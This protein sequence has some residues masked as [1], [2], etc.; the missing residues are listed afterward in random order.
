[1]RYA[2]LYPPDTRTGLSTRITNSTRWIIDAYKYGCEAIHPHYKL[3]T[4]SVIEKA[5][6]LGM[7]VNIWTLDDPHIAQH[8]LR[9]GIDGI[10]TND[11]AKI[12]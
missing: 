9:L 3:A 10:I 8:L 7:K 11:P 4:S 1:M 6:N 12:T 2:L 5:H